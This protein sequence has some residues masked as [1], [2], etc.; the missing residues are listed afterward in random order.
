MTTHPK[1]NWIGPLYALIAAIGFSAKAIFI[2]IVYAQS[3]VDPVTLLA[4]RMLFALPFFL[5]MAWFS[6]R[7][8]PAAIT[9]RDWMAL[10]WLGFL[11]YYF[12]SLL[13][14]LGLQY[15][16]AALERLILFLY[17]TIVMALAVVLYGK[18]V[19]GREVLALLLSFS[20]IAAVFVSD[21]RLSETPRALWTGGALVFASSVAYAFY[22][23]GNNELIRK[24]GAM[25]FTGI[26]ASISAVF[27]LGHFFVTRPVAALRIPPAMYS[28]VLALAV[29][30][31]ALPIWMTSEAIRRAGPSRVAI[32][33]SVGPIFT[34]WMGGLFLGEPVTAI[35]MLGALL[36]LGGVMLVTNLG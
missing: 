22:L 29:V 5:W 33:G 27:I 20:G 24:L 1:R 6:G 12:A 8:T 25:R 23:V 30:S 35:T 34:I 28:Q 21:L 32:V 15:I 19:H 4:L 31:T 26:A 18:P 11:G 13:D 14:F 7:R 9:R 36:V 17:P 16:S 2:K 10:G 3:R